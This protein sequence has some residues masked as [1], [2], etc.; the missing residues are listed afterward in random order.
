MSFF[1]FRNF[2]QLFLFTFSGSPTTLSIMTLSIMGLFR[3]LSI[4]ILFDILLCVAFFIVMPSV[5]VVSTMASEKALLHSTPSSNWG[6][7][8]SHVRLFYE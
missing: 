8:F 1:H 3:I 6:C 2:K 5:I 4:T 7:I